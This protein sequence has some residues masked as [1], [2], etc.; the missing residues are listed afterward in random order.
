TS[1]NVQLDSQLESIAQSMESMSARMGQFEQ[2][3]DALPTADQG[4]SHP[5]F[6][7]SLDAAEINRLIEEALAAHDVDD[8]G[9]A[10]ENSSEE[11][12]LAQAREDLLDRSVGLFL[13]ENLSDEDREALWDELKELGLIEEAISLLETEVA[14]DPE[15]ADLINQLG[16]AYLQPIIRDGVAG[17]DAS[18]WSVKADQTY[19]RVLELDP[20]HWEARFSKAISYSFWP[21]MFGKQPEAIRHFE[22]LV[23]QQSNRSAQPEYA[24]THILLGNLYEQSGDHEAAMATWQLGADRY[25]EDADL[26]KKLGLE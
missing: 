15:N 14:N 19:D 3:L 7:R 20:E 18:K 1:T 8:T 24:Q 11:M 25:P 5:G 16:Y 12:Q 6:D 17:M 10:S 13:D 26:R 9:T 4:A 2:R 23:D 21:P 22:I